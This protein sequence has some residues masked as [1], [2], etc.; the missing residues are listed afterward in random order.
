MPT[1]LTSLLLFVVMLL[2]GFAYLVGKERHGTERRLSPFR[3]T[4]A[5]VAASITSELV[6]LVVF[7]GVRALWPSVTPDVGALVRDGG[8]YLRGNGD[9]HGQYANVAAWGIGLLATAVVLAYLATNPKVRRRLEWLTGPYPHDSTVSAWWIL[10]DR[11]AGNRKIELVAMLDD[12]SCVRGQFGSFNTSADDS[13]DRDL[14]L[15][16]PIFYRPAGSSEETLYETAAVCC[17]ASRIVAL[18]VNY[19]EPVQ[20]GIT[21]LPVAG[22]QSPPVEPTAELGASMSAEA[23]TQA[24]A[25]SSSQHQASDPC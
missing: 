5:I 12:G 10:F 18:F 15:Q 4:V 20:P 14:I 17:P 22:S 8:T 2:P 19:V 25:Q 9:H 3:E 23:P 13:P 6:V 16:R 7:A 24:L 1:T 21:P 11:W